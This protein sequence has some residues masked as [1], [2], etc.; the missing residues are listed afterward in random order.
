MGTSFCRNEAHKY[1]RQWEDIILK[2]FKV[3]VSGLGNDFPTL[4]VHFAYVSF[5][6]A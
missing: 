6:Q 2:G 4:L 5:L 1:V 3:I